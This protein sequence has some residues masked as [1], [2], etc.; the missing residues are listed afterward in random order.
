MES[1][2]VVNTT[3]RCTCTSLAVALL[4]VKYVAVPPLYSN[5]RYQVHVIYAVVHFCDEACKVPQVPGIPH[6]CLFAAD[7]TAIRRSRYL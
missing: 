2:G 7:W 3:D 4:P 6:E 1:V 5:T